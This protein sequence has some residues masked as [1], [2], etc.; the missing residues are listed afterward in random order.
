[1][2]AVGTLMFGPM[3]IVVI[4]TAN[5]PYSRS[6]LRRKTKRPWQDNRHLREMR[7]RRTE[8]RSLRC[9]PARPAQT[10]TR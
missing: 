8:A 2:R 9:V 5:R 3:L 4:T 10:A 6:T 1:M 7:R